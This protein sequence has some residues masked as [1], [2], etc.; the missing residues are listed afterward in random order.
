LTHFRDRYPL[1]W[2]AEVI[3]VVAAFV[4]LFRVVF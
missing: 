1:V 4:V 2:V 3:A